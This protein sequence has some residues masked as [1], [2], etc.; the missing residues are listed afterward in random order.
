MISLN[1]RLGD[2][3]KF[4]EDNKITTNWNVDKIGDSDI[5]QSDGLYVPSMKGSDGADGT[6]SVVDDYTLKEE[7]VEYNLDDGITKSLMEVADAL[8]N[9]GDDVNL[10][11]VVTLKFRDG[12]EKS[13][14]DVNGYWIFSLAI[15][16]M[17]YEFNQDGTRE[18]LNGDDLL[19][20]TTQS[21]IYDKGGNLSKD[22]EYIDYNEEDI[23]EGDILVSK[24]LTHDVAR[25]YRHISMFINKNDDKLYGFDFGVF[26]K[27]HAAMRHSKERFDNENWKDSL[28]NDTNSRLA[29]PSD[30][31]EKVIRYVPSE[32]FVVPNHEVVVPIYSMAAWTTDQA[33]RQIGYIPYTN[34]K[35][36]KKKQ[37]IINEVNYLYDKGIGVTSYIIKPN[38]LLQ[39]VVI[40][41]DDNNA[42]TH[43]L[44]HGEYVMEDMNRY[45]DEKTVALFWVKSVTNRGDY[46]G[47]ISDI[48]LVCLWSHNHNWWVPGE[49][50]EVN[51]N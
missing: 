49:N 26:D 31:Y 30:E 18:Y 32:T 38:S 36:A 40:G 5:K 28:N 14:F 12:S 46:T 20:V 29:I 8:N 35:H 1:V 11:D 42:F 23:R 50:W 48:E 47:A 13:G 34:P 37:D 7:N 9:A 24:I 22:W 51:N 45:P 4:T 3:L 19:E 39:F 41:N 17:G 21:F 2:G 6:G 10:R 15:R 44:P 16:R 33:N 27:L 25:R 43:T